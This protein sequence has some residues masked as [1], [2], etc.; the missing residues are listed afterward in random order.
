MNFILHA[1]PADSFA[2]WVARV[3]EAEGWCQA[4]EVAE[5]LAHIGLDK[6]GARALDP[7]CKRAKPKNIGSIR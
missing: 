4:R 6:S 5:Q 1:L 7:C 2:Q 3:Q